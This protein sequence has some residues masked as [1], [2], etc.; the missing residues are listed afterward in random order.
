MAVPNQLK[1]QH[2]LWRAGFGPAVE[3]LDSLKSFTSR[4]VYKALVKASSKK[5]RY[6]SVADNYLDGLVMGIDEV[7]KA[8]QRELTPEEKRRRQQQ[9]RQGVRNL[10]GQW[11][12]EMVNSD[13]QLREKMAF[14]WHGHFAC[15]NLNVFYQQDLLHTNRTHALG[16]FRQLLKE[17]SQSA[18][19]L[20]F[21]NN[22][23]N[24]KGHPNENFAR[25]LMELFTLGRGHY[26]ETD[27]KEAA[28]AFTGWS[29]NARGQFIF[30][31]L[32]HDFGSKTVLGKTGN[33]DGDAVLDIILH[34]PR[35]AYFITEKIYR[36]LVNEIVDT[37]K[38]KWLADRFYNSD[39]EI[40]Q[41]LDDI[42]TSEWFYAAGNIG[43]KIKSPI[44][45]LAGIQR[46]IPMKLENNESLMLIQRLLGQ[47]LFYPPNVAGW[48]GGR[49][50]IDSS[51]LM[52]RLRLPQLLND[53]DEFN[54]SPKLDDDQMM[55]RDDRDQPQTAVAI[56]S[57][58]KGMRSINAS[59]DW[60]DLYQ[61][62]SATERG[63][64]ENKIAAV[65]LQ[66]NRTVSTALVRRYADESDRESFI[67]S[68][69][70][71]Y[72]ST[73]EYQLC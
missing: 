40:G 14:F 11:L 49:A 24:R 52:L 56:A 10:N 16:N 71:Q 2:L 48:P 50:W 19:I 59:L 34:Q 66:T 4:E 64:L 65:L 73:P 41:L 23:Q 20:F 38:V 45:L 39:Y 32:Q 67:K 60:K 68:V 62:L 8:Q 6:I 22:Q 69:T 43:T 25:E 61:Y 27:V 21:L 70:L 46:M 37:E 36:F 54:L 30:R 58:V 9:N 51:T 3:Q 47:V 1:N 7:S 17:V 13:A 63:K 72:M 42:F 31:R 15:R 33:L 26:T 53:N 18:A 28:R 44:E 5:P 29:A 55:G 57:K 12:H 35:T